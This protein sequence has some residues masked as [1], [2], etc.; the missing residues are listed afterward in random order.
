MSDTVVA[1]CAE[2][3]PHRVDVRSESLRR[4]GMCS[5]VLKEA[6]QSTTKAGNILESNCE[7]CRKLK[8]D[9]PNGLG[10]GC[11]RSE[12]LRYESCRI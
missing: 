2:S 9:N 5:A 6:A 3:I 11:E 12:E 4:N 10:V 1:E 8:Y 7:R